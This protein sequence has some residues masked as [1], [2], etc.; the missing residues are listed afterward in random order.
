MSPTPKALELVVNKI[1]EQGRF[2]KKN[3]KTG[4]YEVLGRKAAV[5]K[6]RQALLD[7]KPKRRPVN[8]LVNSSM[9]S[10]SFS[11]IA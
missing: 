10:V 1:L 4:C 8:L 6:A 3:N 11:H 2:L 5:R 7:W 9:V